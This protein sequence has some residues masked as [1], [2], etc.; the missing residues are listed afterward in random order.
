MGSPVI[1]RRVWEYQTHANNQVN[2]SQH[3]KEIRINDSLPVARK[4]RARPN[5]CF[6][7]PSR[8]L[9]LGPR[10]SA[11][12][13]H[14]H[15][16]KYRRHLGWRDHRYRSVCR[17]RHSDARTSYFSTTRPA[18]DRFEVACAGDNLSNDLWSRWRVRHRMAR[19]VAANAP[20][21]HSRHAWRTC[22][23][24]RGCRD[25]EQYCQVRPTLVSDCVGD[26][27]AAA[28]AVWWLAL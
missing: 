13:A 17:H 7:L 21:L 25:L 3:Q 1:S 5:A 2:T 22:V 16:K 19:A 27:R 26:T 20:R 24:H 10:V 6:S 12:G 8:Q 15:L 9:F 18:N 28:S 23:D 4:S 14:V 11:K